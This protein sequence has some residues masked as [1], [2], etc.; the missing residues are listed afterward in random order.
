MGAPTLPLAKMSAEKTMNVAVEG[1]ETAEGA[2]SHREK[3][4]M[5]FGYQPYSG[6]HCI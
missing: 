4:I 3:K 5:P 6:D 1:A 2:K